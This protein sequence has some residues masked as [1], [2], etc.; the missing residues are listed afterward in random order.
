[1]YF[2]CVTVRSGGPTV[3]FEAFII[4]LVQGTRRVNEAQNLQ[5]PNLDLGYFAPEWICERRS[6]IVHTVL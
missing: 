4:P 2:V 6:G 1:M 5:V 3:T